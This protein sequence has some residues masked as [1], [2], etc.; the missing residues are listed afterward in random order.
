MRLQKEHA[1]V[2]LVFGLGCGGKTETASNGSREA[3]ASS[4]GSGG[5]SE[6]SD[7][8]TSG[9]ASAGSAG[10]SGHSSVSGSNGGTGDGLDAEVPDAFPVT[11]AQ[12]TFAL[13]PD[14]PANTCAITLAD[15]ACNSNADCTS[16]RPPGCG[17]IEP[18]Y[19]VNTTYGVNVKGTALC[20]PPPCA[21]QTN[22]DGGLYTCPVDASGPYTED[23]QFVPGSQSVAVACVNHQCLTYAAGGGFAADR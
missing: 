1:V 22:A 18:V 16:Y 3:N 5:S 4:G 14:A 21:P 17:C 11:C 23:C 10:S 19:G 20:P 7:A 2:I 8:S 15:V 9:S 13:D 6:I 12:Y